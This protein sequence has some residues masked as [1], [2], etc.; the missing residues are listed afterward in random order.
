MME[1]HCVAHTQAGPAAARGHSTRLDA[2]E[3]VI[4]LLLA[5]P[6]ERLGDMAHSDLAYAARTDFEAAVEEEAERFG[7][8][9]ATEMRSFLR[10]LRRRDPLQVTWRIERSLRQGPRT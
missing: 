7:L 8:E 3:H 9:F 4:A 10:T 2:V 1:G 6:D 5:S